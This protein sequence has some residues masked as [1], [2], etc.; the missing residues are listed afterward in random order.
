MSIFTPQ[1]TSQRAKVYDVEAKEW[2]EFVRQIDTETGIIS[3]FNTPLRAI[4]GFVESYE[5]QYRSIRPIYGW[6]A[7]PVLF[8]CYGRINKETA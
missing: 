5:L 6:A 3:L 7:M 8:H 1:N 4:D 2:L